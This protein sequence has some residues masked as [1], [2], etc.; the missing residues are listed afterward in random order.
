MTGA[1]PP[2]FSKSVEITAAA[3]AAFLWRP[4]RRFFFTGGVSF[5]AAMCYCW[6]RAEF[7]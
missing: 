6:F 5:V 3:G 2:I 7:L 1:A 4:T